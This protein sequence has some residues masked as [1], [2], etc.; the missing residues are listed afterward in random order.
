MQNRNHCV[1]LSAYSPYHLSF[2]ITPFS[3]G[4]S[5]DF[6]LS[7]GATSQHL[8]LVKSAGG[9]DQTKQQQQKSAVIIN[10]PIETWSCYYGAVSENTCM[11]FCFYLDLAQ[12]CNILLK[13][14]AKLFATF[15]GFGTCVL[16][17]QTGLKYYLSSCTYSCCTYTF[18]HLYIL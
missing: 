14:L 9:P 13:N 2:L 12:E 6:W 4:K 8:P 18:K 17:Y 10:R 5:R 16:I 15:L 11:Q 1:V 3:W 7:H